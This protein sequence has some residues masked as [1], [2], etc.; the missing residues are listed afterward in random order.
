MLSF[1]FLLRSSSQNCTVNFLGKT[2]QLKMSQMHLRRRRLKN[3]D[4]FRPSSVSGTT[5]DRIVQP[6]ILIC[7]S[8]SPDY[9]LRVLLFK[10]KASP[11]GGP[12]LCFCKCNTMTCLWRNSDCTGTTSTTITPSS[13]AIKKSPVQW[14]QI[15]GA[16]PGRGSGI[17]TFRARVHANSLGAM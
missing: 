4:P 2:S 6:Q 5:F 8:E 14:K 3:S 15:Q 1:K 11:E 16:K 17:A 13:A 9:S 7:C 12:S 10:R